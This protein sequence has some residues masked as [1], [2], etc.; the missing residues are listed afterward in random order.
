MVVSVL[1]VWLMTHLE[2]EV[3]QQS[4]ALLPWLLG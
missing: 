1:M 3:V 4:H 2:W